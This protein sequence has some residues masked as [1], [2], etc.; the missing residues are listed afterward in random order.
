[1]PSSILRAV[2]GLRSGPNTASLY[3][4][5]GRPSGNRRTIPHAS[6]DDG[7]IRSFA[8]GTVEARGGEDRNPERPSGR[9]RPMPVTQP[10]ATAAESRPTFGVVVG[11]AGCAFGRGEDSYGIRSVAPN[12]LPLRI[13]CHAAAKHD[14]RRHRLT[15][16]RR[17]SM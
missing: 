16:E 9:P 5:Q 1:M 4:D 11:T 17:R 2:F 14:D 8:T 10:D 6:F 13:L 3:S 7:W 15:S 12:E